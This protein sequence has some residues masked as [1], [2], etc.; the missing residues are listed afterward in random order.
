MPLAIQNITSLVPTPSRVYILLSTADAY[1]DDQIRQIAGHDIIVLEKMNGFKTYGNNEEGSLSA[2]KRIKAVHPNIKTLFYLNAM[3]HY[4]GYAANDTYKEEWATRDKNSKTNEVLMFKGRYFWYD[5]RNLD[6]REWWITRALEMLSHDEIDGI[7]IDGI[8]KTSNRN[9][10]PDGHDAAYFDT[11]T[12]LRRRL[13]EGKLLI[14]NALCAKAKG[15]VGGK[16][17]INHL[18]YLDGSYIEGWLHS[19]I[20][21][22]SVDLMSAALKAGRIVMPHAEPDLSKEQKGELHRMKSLDNK[23][24][25]IGKRIGFSL[26]LF[27]L[28][29]E[30]YAY[31]AYH[32]GVDASPATGRAAF[33]S[34]RFEEITRELGEPK[35]PYKKDEEF[36]YSREFEH[37]KV[38]VNVETR[39]GT[40]TVV[41]GKRHEEL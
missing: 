41:D 23:Y 14:G 15:G 33:D 38:V 25:F 7:F 30:P 10:C 17:N 1:S 35:G 24:A 29:V 36:L 6:F 2:A 3:I 22:E 34:N 32:Y 19:D 26:G 11:A 20:A 37:L 40:L 39:E 13:P 27:L 18:K 31:F 4:P 12:E 9:L 21:I 5:H 16:G 8:M 28:C